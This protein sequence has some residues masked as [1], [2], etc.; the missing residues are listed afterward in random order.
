MRFVFHLRYLPVVLVS[1]CLVS[2]PAE[3]PADEASTRVASPRVKICHLPPGNPSNAH[4]ISV[5]QAALPAHLAHGDGAGPCV[6]PPDEEWDCYPAPIET[7]GIGTCQRGTKTCSADGQGY[8]ECVGAIVPAP[9][10]C[11]DQLD[12]DCD[13]VVDDGC[14]TCVPASEACGNGV[15]DDCDGTVD[16]GC[17]CAPGAAT[18]CYDGP[19]G[20][21]GVGA[22]AA[23]VQT[24]LA[25][26]SG[27]GACVGAV[28]PAAEACGNGVDDDCDGTADEGC[29]CTPGTATACYDGPAGTAGV[30]AC[31][32]GVQTCLADGSGYGACVG[33][34]G[35][36]AE[37][38]GN[39]VDDDCDGAV[40][41]GCVC[42]PGAAAACYDGPAGTA[43]VGACAAGVQT[44]LADGSGYGA[45]VGAVGPAAE[46]CGNGVDDDCDGAVDEGCVCAPG[47][48][49]ACY[50]GPV[51]TGGVGACAA[52]VQ[53]CLP[54]GSG[55]GVC[56]GA[57]GPAFEICG[58]G[59]DN[60][61]DGA[62]DDGC[63]GDR[64]WRDTNRNGVQDA[65]EPG[66][67]GVVF[68]LRTASGAL[69]AVATS[70]A[71]G[72][73]GFN[74]VPAGTYYVEAIA[75]A[76]YVLTTTDAGGSDLVDSDFDQ[77]T[78]AT[79]PR[80]F[81]GAADDSVDAG[82]QPL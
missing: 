12:T 75:P 62:V 46:A 55:Y 28:G 60:D 26:G 8:G 53:T 71:T 54:D 81:V 6:C 41:E 7:D 38:C 35:P 22:C 64:A 29:V 49:A 65:G 40:D 78:L 16:E 50:D 57:V 25:D 77:E 73:Y 36:A 1:A 69:V 32:A 66:L 3:A 43:G 51:G 74:G 59:V 58:D 14:T 56:V 42:A 45:C 23:G 70:D 13:G 18:A 9:E 72:R 34:V 2:E 44:C 67:A 82:F 68:L 48:A 19:A 37:A 11:G 27:Y 80:V 10:V 31:A 61:C 52:G 30:G 4:T 63:V 21:A 5:T 15:D 17:V 39:G 24:C 20:T 76:G 47:A 79:P 33:A